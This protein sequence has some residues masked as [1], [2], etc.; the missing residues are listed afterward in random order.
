VYTTFEGRLGAVDG[1]LIEEGRLRKLQAP[2]ELDLGKRAAG[3]IVAGQPDAQ[4]PG[5][6]IDPSARADGRTRRD[7]RVL[8]ELLLSPLSD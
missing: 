3:L 5:R 7:P 8:V 4:L 6:S 2:E 1:R